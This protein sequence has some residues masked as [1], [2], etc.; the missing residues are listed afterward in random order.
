MQRYS[1]L[2][3][4]SDVTT[5]CVA[6]GVCQVSMEGP[7]AGSLSALRRELALDPGSMLLFL[8]ILQW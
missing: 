3:A 2:Y 4:L 5:L 6:R 1:L 8:G 7:W